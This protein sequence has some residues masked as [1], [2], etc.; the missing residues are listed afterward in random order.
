[1][2]DDD[3]D[4]IAMT[5]STRRDLERFGITRDLFVA[6]KKVEV[7]KDVDAREMTV[8]C[9]PGNKSDYFEDDVVA[10]CERCGIQV[11][12]RPHVPVGAIIICTFCYKEDV[13]KKGLPDLEQLR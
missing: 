13:I 12:H 8:I 2:P 5:E 7:V 10:E 6:G 11:H 4:S 3:D 9:L 1:M